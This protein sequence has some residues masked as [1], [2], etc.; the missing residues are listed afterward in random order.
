MRL[1]LG[2]GRSRLVR[3]FLTES[4]LLAAIGG[5][6][7]IILAYR[8]GDMLA[9]GFNYLTVDVQPDMRLLVFTGGVTLRTGILFGLAPA[10]RATRVDVQ[11]GLQRDSR[12]SRSRVSH[13]LVV[14]QLALSLVAVVGAVLLPPPLPTLR[15]SA[16]GMNTRHL[17]VFHLA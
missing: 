1:A 17:P 5:T 4:L 11:P 2:A 7:G 12:S 6:L 13:A 3:Q 10:I 8:A 15:P 9:R 16:L 14:T